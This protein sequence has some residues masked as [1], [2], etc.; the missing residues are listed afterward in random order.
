MPSNITSCLPG[1]PLPGLLV[2]PFICSLGQSHDYD[3][4]CSLVSF[5]PKINSGS[6]ASSHLYSL[7]HP[8]H[9]VN[10]YIF[11]KAPPNVISH[12]FRQRTFPLLWSPM[13][14]DA[15]PQEHTLRL[16]LHE[17]IVMGLHH[18]PYAW[19]SR[20]DSYSR[21]PIKPDTWTSLDGCWLH[22]GKNGW[23]GGRGSTLMQ[24]RN[25]R[26]KSV[27]GK[28]PVTFCIMAQSQCSHSSRREGT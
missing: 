22:G 11:F 25:P 21:A 4:T 15:T 14:V 3:L 9:L 28:K 7:P 6:C 16:C 2:H 27:P 18:D 20:V 24:R 8:S 13:A 23:V 19:L 17:A 10:S 26:S 1:S 5:L 12:S